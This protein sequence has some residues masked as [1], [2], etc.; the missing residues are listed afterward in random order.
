MDTNAKNI[1]PACAIHPGSV[2]KSE[3]EA[4]DIKPKNFALSIKEPYKIINELIKGHIDVSASMAIKL[5]E[6]LGIP[7]KLW[8]NLQSRYHHVMQC[9]QE[10]KASERGSN[11]EGQPLYPHVPA[12]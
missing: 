4:R 12:V 8:L 6:A 1:I 10:I 5:E 9:K 7:S 11:F 3:L 2:L